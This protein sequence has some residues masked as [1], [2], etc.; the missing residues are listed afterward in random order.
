M[1]LLYAISYL[2]VYLF[3]YP[4]IYLIIIRGNWNYTIEFKRKWRKYLQWKFKTCVK[5]DS[6]DIIFKILFFWF[7]CVN[8]RLRFR[9]NGLTQGSILRCSNFLSFFD[10]RFWPPGMDHTNRSFSFHFRKPRYYNPMKLWKTVDPFFMHIKFTFNSNNFSSI[11]LSP[12]P[13]HANWLLIR[14]SAEHCIGMLKDFGDIPNS[15]KRYPVLFSEKK[16]SCIYVK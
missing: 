6:H 13:A 4:I 3:I 16:N 10:V 1:L 8:Q 12:I 9:I 5:F 7:D 14:N 11:P 2:L 15:R